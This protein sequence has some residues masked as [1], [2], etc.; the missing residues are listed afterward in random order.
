MASRRF[1]LGSGLLSSGA[2]IFAIAL[3]L[4][5]PYY[6]LD[7]FNGY[8]LCDQECYFKGMLDFIGAAVGAIFMLVGAMILIEWLFPREPR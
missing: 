1:T 7:Q 4:S 5:N 2:V 3:Y 6:I 8:F